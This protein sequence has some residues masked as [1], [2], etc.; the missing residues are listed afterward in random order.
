[1]AGA[2][3]VVAAGLYTMW[4]EAKTKEKRETVPLKRRRK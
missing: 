3:L 1:L 2:G 4:R